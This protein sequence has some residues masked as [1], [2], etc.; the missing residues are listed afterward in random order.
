MKSAECRDREIGRIAA[1]AGLLSAAA[2]WYCVQHGSL[3]FYGDAVAHINIARRVFDSRTPGLLQLGTVWLPLPH[4]LMLPFLFSDSMWQTGVGGSFP[5]LAAYVAAVLGVFR[6]ARGWLPVAGGSNFPAWLAAIVFASNPSLLYLQTTAMTEALYLALFVWAVVCF[7]EFVQSRQSHWL[8]RC[9]MCTAAAALTRYDG[10]FLAAVLGLTLAAM[11]LR[12]GRASAESWKRLVR[13]GFLVS[14]VPV[15]WLAYNAVIY[16]NP[17]EFANG[18]YSARAIEQKTSVQGMPLHPGADN[19]VEAGQYFLKSGQLIMATG[20]WAQA[21]MVV[22][23]AASAIILLATRRL[24]PL[25]LLWAPLLFYM[26][27]VARGGVPIFMPVWWPFSYYNTRYGMQLLPLMSVS[28]AVVVWFAVSRLK[29]AR[30]PVLV[31]AVALAF[32][33]VSYGRVWREGPVAYH[34]A[35]V[36]SRTRLALEDTVAGVLSRMPHDATFLMYSGDHVGAFQQAGIPLRRT[37]NEGNHR[38][39]VKPVDPDG[40]WERALSDPSR[41]VDYVVAADGDEVSRR[42]NRQG[43]ELL[44]KV[45]STGQPEVSIFVTGRSSRPGVGR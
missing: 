26:L 36:N 5:S 2:F 3:L 25:L 34:E 12:N 10:W 20:R 27:S 31:T 41:Y 28:L 33:T 29:N 23:V 21:W 39:W 38:P 18:P 42:L 40:L 43:L 8:M 16:R 32:V 13:F 35:W 19:L 11:T 22:T 4:L 44:A 45:H 17:L 6:L 14:A 24:S 1:M 15:L 37:I 7:G 30:A 9:G